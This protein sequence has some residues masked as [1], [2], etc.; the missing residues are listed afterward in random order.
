MT[1]LIGTVL[2]TSLA[3]FLLRAWSPELFGPRGRTVFFGAGGLVL[4][5]WAAAR[6][7]GESAGVLSPI[8]RAAAGTWA[9][10]MLIC[11]GIAAPLVMS[12]WVV[13]RLKRPQPQPVP[14]DDSRRRFLGGLM[15]PMA[16]VSTSAGGTLAGLK[17]FQVRHEEIRI[18]GLPR[19]LDGF[20][21]GQLTDVHIGDFIDV[22][23]LERAVDALDAEGVDLQVQTGDLIDDMS[24]LD[25]TM[26]ALD[27]VKAR[28]GMVNIIGNHEIWRGREETYAAYARIGVNGRVKFLVDD[29]LLI[30]HEGAK[31]RIVGVDY[32]MHGTRGH[33]LP[34]DE[35]DALMR[36]SA[37]KA[38]KGVAPD[39]TVLCLSH[40]PDFFPI[41][42]EHGARLQLSGHTHGGQVG[43]LRMPLFSFAFEYMLGQYQL[44]DSH[45]YVSGGTGH[46]MPF[47]VG[48]P[49]EV[50]VLTLRAV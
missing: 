24:R 47:R 40:H 43:F 18:R 8:A 36:R 41:A 5:L 39:E 33:R 16:A 23:Y 31:L 13:S 2:F 12:R 25:A 50:T 14:V 32:P 34:K 20:R 1:I 22:D 46:W 27:R 28:H 9:I 42:A 29:N 45:L 17:P 7:L 49:T 15:V 38:W 11:I 3:F 10:T 44:G 37:E 4:A 21:I 6:L 19:A 48:V 30:E 35:R 26:A